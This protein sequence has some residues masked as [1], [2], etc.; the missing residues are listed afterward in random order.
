MVAAFHKRTF[1]LETLRK[2]SY[3]GKEGVSFMG[4]SEAAGSIGFRTTGVRIPFRVLAGNLPLP[5]I[6]HWKQKHFVV[7][8]KISG[9]K[10]WVA[11]PAA[12][13]IRYTREDF[14]R[15]WA[16]T[17]TEGESSGLA[18]ILEPT[19]AFFEKEDEKE[20]R[21]GFRFLLEYFSLYRKYLFQLLLGLFIA[22]V[23]RL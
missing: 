5:A 20:T 21:G 14:I 3:I 15:N 9:R 7:V 18:L 13:L 1:S 11:D 6:V 8:Y 17:V 10:V 22:A 2:K 4:L 16:S 23:S 19:P 12:G